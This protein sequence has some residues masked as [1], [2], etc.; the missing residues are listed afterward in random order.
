MALMD[1]MNRPEIHGQAF[2]F[3]MCTR[4][5]VPQVVSKIQKLMD[6]EDVEPIYECSDH[7]EI[8]HQELSF[9][10]AKNELG[11]VPAYALDEGLAETID[12]Y[13]QHLRGPD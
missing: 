11:W 9:E 2:N 6:A 7:G 3:G 4:I 8:I 13:R 1:A 12:W 10:K 5:P